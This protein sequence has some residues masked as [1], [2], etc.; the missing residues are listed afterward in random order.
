MKRVALAALIVFVLDQITKLGVVFGLGLIDR[1]EIDVLP[2]ILNFRMAWNQGVNFG[3]LSSHTEITRWTLIALSLAIS[4]WVWV[5][6]SR[7]NHGR[8]ARIST[9]N[10]PPISSAGTATSSKGRLHANRPRCCCSQA[11]G[12]AAWLSASVVVTPSSATPIS[13]P[14]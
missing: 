10:V 13:R 12:A 2:P 6:A 4:I 8:W 7:Q 3:L 11:N 9:G 1:G 14:T 5:W